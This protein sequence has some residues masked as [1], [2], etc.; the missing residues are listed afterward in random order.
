M[1]TTL[2]FLFLLTFFCSCEQEGDLTQDA[3]TVIVNQPNNLVKYQGVF[4]PTSGINGSGIVKI[5]LENN[6]FKLALENYS[7]SSGPDLKVYL[8]KSNTPT[9]FV[10]LGNLN[11][12]TVYSVPQNVDLMVYKYVLIHC[13]QYNHLFAVAELIQN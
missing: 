3:V 8:S 4:S 7:I 2:L 1:K 9:D 12:A 6:Q 11:S 5:Y 13:Q 10:N